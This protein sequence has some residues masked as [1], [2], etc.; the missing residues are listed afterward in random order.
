MNDIFDLLGRASELGSTLLVVATQDDAAQRL[1]EQLEFLELT[2][3]LVTPEGVE[4]AVRSTESAL[5]LVVPRSL[6]DALLAEVVLRATEARTDLPLVLFDDADDGE[7]PSEVAKRF[8]AV[9]RPPVRYSRL[10]ELVRELRVLQ[11]QAGLPSAERPEIFRSL[12]G[13]SPA[14]QA[15]RRMVMRVAPWE[16]TV[17]L[18][19]ETG[20]GK[21]VV[22][23][24]IHYYSTRRHGPFVAVNCGAI[25]PDLLESE[26]FGH[27]KGAFTGALTA[28]KGRFE[29]ASGGT[30][31]LDE[32]G[33]MPLEM[34]VK[35]LRV[36][37]ERRFEPLGSTRTVTADVRIIAATHRNLEEMIGAG[38]FR[39][40]LYY[41]LN[42]VP[43]EV[44]PLRERREDLPL[45]ISELNARLQARGMPTARFDAQALAAMFRYDW[46][47]NVRELA[48]LVERCAILA[49]DREV[50][51][52]DLP[53]KLRALMPQEEQQSPDAAAEA[54][55]EGLGSV[56]LPVEQGM[57]LKNVL[58][59]IEVR[60]IRQA[61]ES[62]EGVVA[63]AAKLL[64]L[65]R[66]TLV[67]KMR[68]FQIG[69]L[70]EVTEF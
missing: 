65:R 70:D 19:G 4:S 5:G 49:P 8:L 24:N 1:A 46:P 37:Q 68:K 3:I 20:T 10:A 62:S 55:L 57:N 25:P 50:R 18:R 22:A 67:E 42:V 34:Q 21:E 59:N 51:L 41:R 2:V 58:D 63:R 16:V 44:P 66:T 13:R 35:L 69:R 27:E 48:N 14:I 11:A 33:D 40:D 29:L 38:R 28:R 54:L 60:L 47:G 30:L 7:K 17:Q 26:L 61:L 12:V 31:F 6:G 64:G 15:V 32:I 45:L 43:I 39:E 9:L 56:G 52:G 36:L 23:R 53:E